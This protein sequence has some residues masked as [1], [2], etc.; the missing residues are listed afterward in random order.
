MIGSRIVSSRKALIGIVD[1]SF[2][3]LDITK[4]NRESVE[5]F[6][7]VIELKDKATYLHSLRTGLLSTVIAES[8]G[9][10]PK[11]MFYA[12]LL[13]DIG[14]ITIDNGTLEKVDYFDKMDLEKM[15]A[16]VM[17]GY[18][19]LKGIHDFSA[20]ILLW[21]HY[22]KPHDPY[23]TDAEMKELQ[24]DLPENLKKKSKEYGLILAF[25]DVYDAMLTRKNSMYEG[26]MIKPGESEKFML[27][28]FKD[29]NMN[30]K[31][32]LRELYDRGVLGAN[33]SSFFSSIKENGI[34]HFTSA[35]GKD[36]QQ[37]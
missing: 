1:E 20:E 9:K 2:L 17:N 26:R 19:I 36:L 25:A 23:P 35:G 30:H 29:H 28:A 21:H 32:T 14:K 18:N 22:F 3:E 15:K 7:K 10:N 24:S 37:D 12:G 4:E 33:Y 16:H 6:L 27:K 34:G 11:P 8:L 31:E 13:H 5:S